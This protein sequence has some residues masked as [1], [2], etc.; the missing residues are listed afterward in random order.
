MMSGSPLPAGMDLAD[1]LHD[2][3]LHA[4]Q[5]MQEVCVTLAGHEVKKFTAEFWTSRQ[6]QASSLHEVS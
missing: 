1:Y 6:R 3:V 5:S 2:A 4:G